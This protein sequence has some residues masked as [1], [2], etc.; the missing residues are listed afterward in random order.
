MR[1]HRLHLCSGGCWLS[2]CRGLGQHII[3]AIQFG[4]PGLL[5]KQLHTSNSYLAALTASLCM[6]NA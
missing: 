3:P 1:G 6:C 5:P 4:V 2:Y